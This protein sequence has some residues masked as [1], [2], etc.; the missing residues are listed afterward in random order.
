MKKENFTY[1]FEAINYST[2]VLR[3]EVSFTIK[4][5]DGNPDV[6]IHITFGENTLEDIDNAM[7]ECEREMRYAGGVASYRR[8]QMRL[9]ELEFM[10]EELVNAINIPIELA[11]NNFM[12]LMKGNK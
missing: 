12:N 2:N 6:P 7:A 4:G 5:K 1:E 11:N 10:R 8:L 9:H 3:S